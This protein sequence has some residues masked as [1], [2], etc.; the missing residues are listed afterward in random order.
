MGRFRTFRLNALVDSN[1]PLSAQMACKRPETDPIDPGT[2]WDVSGRQHLVRG[3]YV[4]GMGVG[5]RQGEASRGRIEQSEI[6]AGA[7]VAGG[8]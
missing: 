2:F 3:V 7:G 6:D 4:C 8:L 1:K 5:S